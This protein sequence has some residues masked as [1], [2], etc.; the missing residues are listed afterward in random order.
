M[1]VGLR[2]R[3]HT[4]LWRVL[5]LCIVPPNTGNRESAL[6]ASAILDAILE[7]IMPAAAHEQFLALRA[8]RVRA[9]TVAISF[10]DVAQARGERRLPCHI[11]IFGRRA[12]LLLHL[13]VRVKRC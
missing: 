13:K 6:W 4:L 3:C 12:R 5:P 10:V 11:K 9:I 8:M 7:H 2:S 1:G